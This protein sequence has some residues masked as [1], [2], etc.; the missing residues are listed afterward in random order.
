MSVGLHH[1]CWAHAGSAWL[2][3]G[4]PIAKIVHV[5][6]FVRCWRL[7]FDV[8]PMQA[9]LKLIGGVRR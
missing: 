4:G 9:H 7:P 6:A 5:K 8:F 2:A 3:H 1:R